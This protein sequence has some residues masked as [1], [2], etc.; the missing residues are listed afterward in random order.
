MVNKKLLINFAIRKYKDEVLCDVVLME[1]T[2]ILLGRS[3][4]Y[5]RQVLHDGLTKSLFF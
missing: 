1:T 2:H 4:Q 5:Y 3:W